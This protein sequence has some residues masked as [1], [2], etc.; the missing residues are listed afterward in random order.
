M[1]TDDDGDSLSY[2]A[3]NLP[4]GAVF[5]PS[6]RSLSWVPNSNQAGTYSVT[7][8]AS[9]GTDTVSETIQI[10]VTNSSSKTVTLSWDASPSS[11]AG[12][13]IYYDTD[14]SSPLNG[15]GA[16]EG[17]SPIDVG[18]VL[19]YVIHGLA[20]DSEHFFA[21]TAYDGSN[22]ESSYSNTVHSASVNSDNTPPVFDAI[23]NK[24]ILEGGNLNFIVSA[25]D[26]DGD[27]LTLSVGSVPSGAGFNATTGV[28]SWTPNNDQS[29]TYAVTFSVSDGTDTVSETIQI[30]VTD[31]PINHAPVLVAISDK[32]V[33]EG[34]T[35]YIPISATDSDGDSLSYSFSSMPAGAVFNSDNNVFAWAT[36]YTQAGSYPITVTVSDGEL[37]D[38]ESF[39]ITVSNTNRAPLLDSIGSKT[40]AENSAL[41]F[42]VNGSDLDGDDV[43][44]G[45]SNLPTGAV[46]N[47]Q[48][49]EFSWN[50][51]YDQAGSYNVTFTASDGNLTTSE[52]V[53]ISVSGVNRAPALASVGAKEVAEGSTLTFTVSGSDVDGDD[54]SYSANNLPDG[55]TF[56]IQTHEF[57]WNPTYEQAGS[58]TATFTVSDGSLTNSEQIVISV[59]DV[60]RAPVLD[61]IETKAVAEGA[62]LSFT[63]SGSDPDGDSLSYS[64]E[65]LP[66]G[67]TFNDQ[68][69]EF[70]WNPTYEQAGSYTVT[71]TASDSVLSASAPVTITVSGVNR[72]P[73]LSPIGSKAVA[74]AV[75][76]QFSLSGSDPDSD[77][78]SY[79]ATGI[80]TGASLD[81]STGAFT[82]TPN[83]TQ[84]NTYSVVF[85][86][87]DGSASASETVQ[88]T[89]T[90]VPVNHA[91]TLATISNVVVAEGANLEIA[92]VANDPDSDPLTYSFSGLPAG[93]VF[94][95]ATSKLKWLPNYTSS[96]VY[97][98]V[99]T[100]SDGELTDTKTFTVTVSD[101]NRAPV[102]N[103]IGVKTVAEGTELSFT[104]LGSDADS[105][106]LSYSA[107]DL[108]NGAV[109]NPVDR[110]FRWTPEF[111][112]TQN[113]IVHRVTFAVSDSVAEDIQLV[114]I[115]VTNVNRPP[116]LAPIGAQQLVEGDSSNLVISASDPDSNTTLTLGASGLPVGAVFSTA[117]NSFTWS[118]ADNQ[119]GIYQVTFSVS[120]GALSDTEEVTFTVGIGNK[121]PVL[122]TVGEQTIAE[123]SELTFVASASDVNGDILSYSAT[124]IPA[125]ASF[126]A[127]NQQFSWVPDYTQ[128]GDF[129]VH[130]SVTDG[131]LSDSETINIAVVNTNQPP[132]ITGAPDTSVMVSTN[133]SFTPVGADQDGDALNYTIINKPE[134]ATFDTVTGELSGTPIE[135]QIGNNLDVVIGVSDGMTTVSL[136]PFSIA[137]VAY[138]H[139]DT[140]GD[141]VIAYQSEISKTVA[142]M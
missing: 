104:I 116:V 18:N 138:V 117:T 78:L 7:F 79:S 122:D 97:P 28:F 109:F 105:D 123:G 72:A 130:I 62:I 51:T 94:D 71:F 121:A 100:I 102:L 136:A 110:S 57:E 69:N 56:N 50:P 86:V 38:S 54:L 99:F 135:A 113:T 20:D 82:W 59:S 124:G 103:D 108:P 4:S 115:N 77:S 106:A 75:P 112:A 10:V 137:V 88:I 60:N 47:S 120:D 30:T 132:V 129:T 68:T 80:P 37:S 44:Y 107:T 84:A 2:S 64:A 39:T 34:D 114:T 139:Q 73:V 87:S 61:S 25:S 141:G 40:V 111:H 36:S 41:V 93:A 29:N 52:H 90:D 96:R 63:V 53:V 89:V 15:S 46:F 16:S 119:A 92:I 13:K 27:S 142:G 134:W 14:S 74:E 48:S 83:L 85:S 66:D 140:D 49:R 42:T 55:A 32:G 22:N 91:P 43:S 101:V 98:V 118:P 12:Y 1:A 76:L 35:Q 65:N 26:A 126:D 17:S 8:S 23:G 128:A 127:D 9:D 45:A 133:Y 81:S 95:A 3:S 58:Y 24:S 6:A 70:V 125:G 131:I 67:A 31:V 33:D 5:N 19:T 11:V 21:V